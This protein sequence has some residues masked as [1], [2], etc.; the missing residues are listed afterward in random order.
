MDYRP[1]D[2]TPGGLKCL[3]AGDQGSSGG[4]LRGKWAG[5]GW[6]GGECLGKGF[7]TMFVVWLA[8]MYIGFTL[9]M[10]IGF[11]LRYVVIRCLESVTM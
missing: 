9:G 11:S 2:Y 7:T 10:L 5:V 3:R 6:F 8:L 1:Y 4:Y